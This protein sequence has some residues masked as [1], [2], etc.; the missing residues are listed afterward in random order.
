MLGLTALIVLLDA[1]P[2]FLHSDTDSGALHAAVLWQ[3]AGSASETATPPATTN[4]AA[5]GIED[6]S[7]PPPAGADPGAAALSGNAGAVETASPPPLTPEQ[8]ADL[9]I[10]IAA[11]NQNPG[12]PENRRTAARHVVNSGWPEAWEWARAAIVSTNRTEIAAALATATAEAANPPVPLV[13]AVLDRLAAPENAPEVAAALM[14][15]VDALPPGLAIPLLRDR[16]MGPSDGAGSVGSADDASRLRTTAITALGLFHDVEAVDALVPLT[17]LDSTTPH[18]APS[19]PAVV[20]AAR[21]ALADLTGLPEATD[22]VAWWAGA[23]PQGR[24]GL[25]AGAL[26]DARSDRAGLQQALAQA[27]SERAQLVAELVAAF[28]QQYRLTLREQRD[29]LLVRYLQHRRREV[30]RLGIDLVQQELSNAIPVAESVTA[31]IFER[32]TDR[33]PEVRSAAVRTAFA[34]DGPRTA[35]LVAGHLA[36]EADRGVRI[37]IISVLAKFPERQATDALVEA[38]AVPAERERA[39]EALATAAAAGFI[40]A[41]RMATI[42]RLVLSQA[43]ATSGEPPPVSSEALTRA[44]VARTD[45]ELAAVLSPERVLLLAWSPDE[46]ALRAIQRVLDLETPS[47]APESDRI[48]ALRVAAA[49]GLAGSGLRDQALMANAS[50]PLIYPFVLRG[51]M[52]RSTGMEA[53]ERVLGIRTADATVRREAL[54]RLMKDLA[55][56]LL[57]PADDLLA[58]AGDIAVEDRVRWLSRVLE[59]RA[60]TNGNGNGNGHPRVTPNGHGGGGNGNGSGQVGGGQGGDTPPPS[61]TGGSNTGAGGASGAASA[62]GESGATGPGV[63]GPPALDSMTKRQL[64]LRLA[65]LE[66]SLG[67]PEGV[68]AAVAAAPVAEDGQAEFRRLRWASHVAM[69]RFTEVPADAPARAWLDAAELRLGGPG[70][71]PEMAQ[72]IVATIEARVKSEP[73]A[74]VLTEPEATRLAELV[75]RLTALP[76]P[77]PAPATGNGGANAGAGGSASASAPSTEAPGGAVA[78][79]SSPVGVEPGEETRSEQIAGAS[80]AGG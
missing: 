23:R 2:A 17:H 68:L 72:R 29:A 20:A 16:A 67:R 30:R 71:N 10:W 64:C 39:A 41:D 61:T 73:P 74:L 5:A 62:G 77:A 4:S 24:E 21:R 66:W 12:D 22:W 28:E 44:I 15:S 40:S 37:E 53:L 55:P 26:A 65:H 33:Q 51:I 14:A 9:N 58:A 38:L 45:A 36:N 42:A 54:D 34:L 50:D 47:E 11:I 49:R 52:N 7:T 80:A 70:L 35:G 59:L 31:A 32:L 13:H 48:R 75:S 18:L 60:A 25:L 63:V 78:D 43:V 76:A 56:G 1:A 69:G 19:D 6:A 57:L 27:E 8:A 79:Q 3:E 46:A